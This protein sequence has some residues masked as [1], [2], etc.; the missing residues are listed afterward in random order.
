MK[1]R[2]IAALSD[3]SQEAQEGATCGVVDC[4]K[5]VAS[6]TEQ[7]AFSVLESTSA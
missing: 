1:K 6:N 5:K 4:H 2:I 3:A 7:K